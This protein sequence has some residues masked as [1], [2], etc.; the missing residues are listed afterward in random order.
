MATVGHVPDAAELNQTLYFNTLALRDSLAKVT[1]LWDYVRPLGS[2][3]LQGE[4]WNMDPA[5][6]DAYFAAAEY[7]NT[8]AEIYGG[9]IAQPEP[10]PFADALAPVLGGQ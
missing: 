1:A 7:A 10:F 6:A 4:P 3:G 8:V 9:Q 5:V 2:A